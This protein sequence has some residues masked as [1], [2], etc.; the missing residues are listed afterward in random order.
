MDLNL[1]NRLPLRV[2][3]YFL[4]K[5]IIAI[6][7]ISWTFSFPFGNESYF[8]AFFV[9]SFILIGL[10]IFLSVYLSECKFLSFIV[11]DTNITIDSGVL[12]KQSKSISFD[13]IQNIENTSGI[14]SRIFNLSEIKI[15]TSSPEQI[16]ISKDG[17]THR[18]TGMLL[19]DSID[20]K[21]L[22][23]FILSKQS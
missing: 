4:V 19:L 13:K 22:K 18:P 1:I 9:P 17:T 15:W 8:L 2:K 12:T 5:I 21:W 23:N 11:H 3:W 10:P 20:A 7:I 16:H 6:I 14:L